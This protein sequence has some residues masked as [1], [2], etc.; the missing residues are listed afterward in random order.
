MKALR[1]NIPVQI[2][3]LPRKRTGNK[4]GE[5]KDKGWKTRGKFQIISNQELLFL[6]SPAAW[7]TWDFLSPVMGKIPFLASPFAPVQE[8]GSG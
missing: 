4:D 2:S 1:S 7:N 8:A 6:R 5:N 3:Q